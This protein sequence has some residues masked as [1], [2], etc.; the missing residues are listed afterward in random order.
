MTK[1]P[2]LIFF[3]IIDVEIAPDIPESDTLFHQY[4]IKCGH[5]IQKLLLSND[6][7]QRDVGIQLIISEYESWL[8]ILDNVPSQTHLDKT[9]AMISGQLVRIFSSSLLTT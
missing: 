7:N 5:T 3:L 1:V 2:S 9:K 6:A 4:R 8:R